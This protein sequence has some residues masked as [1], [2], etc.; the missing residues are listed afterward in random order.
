VNRFTFGRGT[1][2]P[3]ELNA[4]GEAASCLSGDIVFRVVSAVGY[5][6]EDEDN[7]ENASR[8]P[9]KWDYIWEANC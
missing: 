9:P 3:L 8:A 4:F 5:G 1:I 2:P 6:T 7:E